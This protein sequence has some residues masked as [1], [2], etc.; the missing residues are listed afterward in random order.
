MLSAR[1]R[2]SGAPGVPAPRQA[3]PDQLRGLALLGIIVVNAPYMAISSAGYTQESIEGW[4]NAASAFAVF[5]FAQGKFYLLFSFLFGYSALFILRGGSAPN[6]RRYRRRLV[7][8]AALG[9]A[10]AIFF[11]NGD[12]LTT[13]AVLGFALLLLLRRS[14][15]SVIRVGV[16][17]FAIS[18]VWLVAIAYVLAN[19]PGVSDPSLTALDTALADGTF[20]EAARARLDALPAVLPTVILLQGGMAFAAFCVGLVAARRSLLAD[21]GR[22]RAL[23]RRLAVWGIAVGLPLQCAAAALQ[24]Q[25]GIAPADPT[26]SNLVGLVLGF[27]TAPILAAGYVGA[28]ALLA[29]RAP[30]TL[31]AVRNGGRASLTVYLG[32]SILLC[33]LFCGWGL[34][35]FGQFGAAVVLIISVAVYALLQLGVRI[36]LTQFDQG[37]FERLLAVWTG[38][39]PPDADR[40]T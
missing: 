7:G 10:H 29:L 37:P 12:I 26:T 18:A 24:L 8:L 5:A 23:W 20:L 31:D 40:V 28:L 25:S 14:D 6:R 36:W 9:L 39:R 15:R 35:W 30:R 16:A 38:P 3:F 19:A 1:R 33:V 17:V 2:G 32:E 4:W 21:L 27:I 13:Y 11:F 22:S 34:G